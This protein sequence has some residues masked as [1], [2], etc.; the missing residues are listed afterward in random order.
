MGSSVRLHIFIGLHRFPQSLR[1][2]SRCPWSCSLRSSSS[3]QLCAVCV[4]C[5]VPT[6]TNRSPY[7]SLLSFT[8]PSCPAQNLLQHLLL[9]T[10]DGKVSLTL[11]RRKCATNSCGMY[12]GITRACVLVLV[13]LPLFSQ[14]CSC[15]IPGWYR[16]CCQSQTS[17]SVDLYVDVCSSC[18]LFC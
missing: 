9:T 14:L 4:L 3:P 5:L 17:G 18:S 6:L 11:K 16:A 15:C 12:Y 10:D 8:R 7:R 1:P 2:P 13:L